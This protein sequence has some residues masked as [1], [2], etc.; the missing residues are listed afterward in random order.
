MIRKEVNGIGV[1]VWIEIVNMERKEI[2]KEIATTTIS[3]NRV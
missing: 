2:E 1:V 3:R